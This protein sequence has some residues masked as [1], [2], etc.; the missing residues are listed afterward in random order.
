MKCFNC[1][2][3]LYKRFH[4]DDFFN[5]YKCLIKYY[6]DYNLIYFDCLYADGLNDYLISNENK[7]SVTTTGCHIRHNSQ[8]YFIDATDI[9][10]KDLFFLYKKFINNMEFL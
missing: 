3:I 1:N 6:V 2:K 10:F 7:I 4:D 8:H 5:C 9:S